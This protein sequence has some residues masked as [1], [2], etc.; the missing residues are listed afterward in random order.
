MN[1]KIAKKLLFLNSLY[2]LLSSLW[3]ILVAFWTSYMSGYLMK[4]IRGD[5]NFKWLFRNVKK[6][7]RQPKGLFSNKR[8]TSSPF[9]RVWQG[10]QMFSNISCQCTKRSRARIPIRGQCVL[11][12]I[13]LRIKIFDYFLNS[14]NY[15]MNEICPVI[16]LNPWTKL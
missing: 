13:S 4:S 16:L 5:K 6:S 7:Q 9:L 10:L 11:L 1:K 2:A 12:Q 15:R 8:Q 14:Q 3:D